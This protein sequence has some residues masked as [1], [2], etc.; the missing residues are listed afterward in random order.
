M[1]DKFVEEMKMQIEKWSETSDLIIAVLRVFS[2]KKL[3]MTWSTTA[4]VFL[5]TVVGLFMVAVAPFLYIKF[6]KFWTF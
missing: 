5:V 1:V 2:T 6:K 4:A 3:V